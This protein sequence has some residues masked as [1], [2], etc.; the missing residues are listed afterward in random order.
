M[1]SDDLFLAFFIIL[2]TPM[3][4]MITSAIGIMFQVKDYHNEL[5]S[6]LS[7]LTDEGVDHGF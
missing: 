1:I 7:K 6:A 2:C 4:I 5:L 3:F